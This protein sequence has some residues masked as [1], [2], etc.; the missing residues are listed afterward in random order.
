MPKFV[1]LELNT[2]KGKKVQWRLVIE[3][4]QDFFKYHKLD[5]ENNTMAFISMDKKKDNDGVIHFLP[6]DAEVMIQKG[7]TGGLPT[8]QMTVARYINAVINSKPQGEKVFPIVELSKLHE[9][10]GLGMLRYIQEHGAIQLNEA[11]GW[12]GFDSFVKQWNGRVLDVIE[13]RDFGFPLDGEILTADTIILE[14]AYMPNCEN[15]LFYKLDG[16]KGLGVIRTIHSLKEVDREWVGKCIYACKNVALRSQLMDDEQLDGFMKM[17]LKMPPKNII[18]FL[19]AQ[20]TDKLKAHP[21]FSQ[22]NKLHNIEI[23]N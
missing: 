4:E 6:E 1:K 8:S 21:L 22:N 3:T 18:L 19:D 12:S 20:A 2:L 9:K 11:G 7:H 17:F 16:R 14:N 10:K 5:V 15:S 13:K 23:N